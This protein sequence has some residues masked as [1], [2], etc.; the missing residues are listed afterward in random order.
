VLCK[1]GK[2]HANGVFF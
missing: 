2:Q 1:V